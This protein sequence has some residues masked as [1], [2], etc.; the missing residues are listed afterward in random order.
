MVVSTNEGEGKT[1]IVANLGLALARKGQRVIIVDADLRRPDLHA[2]FGVE[3]VYGLSRMVGDRSDPARILEDLASVE[4]LAAYEVDPYIQPTSVENL[5]IV[6][7]GPLPENPSGILE[8]PYMGT[9]LKALTD[10]ADVVLIDTPP[11][12]ATGDSLSLAQHVKECVF[13]VGAGRLEHH[14][15]SWAKNLL[16]NVKAEILGVILNMAV[17]EAREYYYYYRR[18]RK[19]RR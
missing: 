17:A 14:E 2:T 9:A 3:N 12:G 6:P 19:V 13:V 1:T 16:L 18:G 15:A 4:D 5:S 8:S 10:A 11:L 7:S